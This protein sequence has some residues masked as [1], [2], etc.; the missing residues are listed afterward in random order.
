[1]P[2]TAAGPRKCTPEAWHRSEPIYPGM[3]HGYDP[4]GSEMFGDMWLRL[5]ER[6]TSESGGGVVQYAAGSRPQ[7][8]SWA[9]VC[10]AHR[11]W[12]WLV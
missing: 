12:A 5:T 2:T 1:M 4:V 3:T 9:P 7:P 10:V 6:G 8:L 11:L